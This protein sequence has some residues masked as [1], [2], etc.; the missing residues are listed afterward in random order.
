MQK[1]IFNLDNPCS[2]LCTNRD[3]TLLAAVGRKVFK[4]IKLSPDQFEVVHNLRDLPHKQI[5]LN[6]S[7]NDVQ[8]NPRDDAQLATA[9]TNG[10]VVLWDINKRT[11]SK[12]AHAFEGH[13]QRAVNKLS[14]HPRE[15][16]I[17]LSGSQD[18]H[19]N[20]FD[21]RQ[22]NVVATYK[23]PDCVRDVKFPGLQVNDN[24]FAA[25][26]DNGMLYIWDR[27]R[28]GENP[29]KQISIHSGPAYCC[30]WHPEQENWIMSA[31]RDKMIK[32]RNAD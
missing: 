13:H 22:K 19:M 32:V 7:S 30:A 3:G 20:V 9:P 5:N 29:M 11:K 15:A 28:T 18:S 4:I 24:Y 1:V 12:L 21:S 2:S 27:R 23:G 31:G 10:S 25:C 26:F 14:F 6:F 16:N 8:W 17:L